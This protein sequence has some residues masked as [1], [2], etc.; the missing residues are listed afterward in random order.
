M[1]AIDS[2]KRNSA[3]TVGDM[4]GNVLDWW[5]FN[6]ANDGTSLEDTLNL[7]KVQRNVL[8]SI[9]QGARVN[10]VG[11]ENIITKNQPG[12]RNGM[13]EHES[14]FKITAVFMSFISF[15]QDQFNITPELINNWSWKSTVLPEKYRSHSVGK[16]S[17]AYFKDMKSPYGNCS[18]DVTD[19]ICIFKYMCIIHNIVHAYRITNAQIEKCKTKIYL[20]QKDRKLKHV[21]VLFVYNPDLTFK[22]NTIVM[23]NQI[24]DEQVGIAIVKTTDMLM[25]DI[26]MYCA[27]EFN[28][29]EEF[30]KLVVRRVT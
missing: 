5:E 20:V 17:L 10:L 29:Y 26:Y 28:E 25:E 18:D 8:Y 19:S 7:C 27:G 4:S 6:G 23:G 30:L 9:F 12:V 15:F 21:P 1:V 13:T 3:F 16:G 14:R 22:Q 24:K 11:I 2:S